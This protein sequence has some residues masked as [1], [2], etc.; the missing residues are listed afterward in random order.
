MNSLNQP[1][2][3]ISDAVQE[4]AW[5]QS[6]SRPTPR[7][8]WN[9]YLN[10]VCLETICPWLQ[11]EFEVDPRVQFSAWEVL[12]GTALLVNQKRW[13]LVPDKSVDCSELR[14][15]QEWID[16]PRL[17]GDYYI[18]IQVDP[19]DQITRIWGY[20]TH[21]RLKT[22]GQYDAE[23]RTYALSSHEVIEDIYVLSV[24][25]QLCPEE[26][27]RSQVNPFA[28][29][30]P[31]Q[32]ENLLQ[33]LAQQPGDQIRLALPFALWGALLESETWS[34][35]LL[36]AE[37][38]ASVVTALAQ[39]FQNAFAE[40]WQSVETFLSPEQVAFNF[41]RAESPQATVQRAKVLQIADQPLLLVMAL[42]QE[43]DGRVGIRI[44]LRSPDATRSLPE[45]LTLSL[46]SRMGD[47]IRSVQ[48]RSQDN[49]IQL[50]RFQCAIG[51]QFQVQVQYLE[52]AVTEDFQC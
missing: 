37:P 10:Q 15:P 43:D 45:D 52:T 35:R 30:P 49:S 8:I 21:A 12:N 51:T 39:W 31:A 38:S 17:V 11:A 44:Q 40:T 16:V 23:D 9:T 26:A 27:T 34:Q 29:M 14:V 32:A 18:A 46:R 6:Q 36:D 2:L 1:E 47:P 22:K 19:D 25:Q 13:I 4:M 5:Q 20:T 33:R 42:T 7:A 48:A 28:D 50:Q 24:V 3:P 41:R